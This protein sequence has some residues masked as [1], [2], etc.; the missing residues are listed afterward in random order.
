M[1][2]TPPVEPIS[3][4]AIQA[5][6][7]GSP[8]H[9]QYNA[10]IR[11]IATRLNKRPE[12]VLGAVYCCLHPD[13]GKNRTAHAEER[14]W[15]EYLPYL[16][17]IAAREIEKSYKQPPHPKVV[18]LDEPVAGTDGLTRGDTLAAP[19]PDSLSEEAALAQILEM[20]ET[21][22]ACSSGK[23]ERAVAQLLVERLVNQMPTLTQEKMANQVGCN[24]STVGRILG[25]L[26]SQYRAHY[27]CFR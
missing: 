12:Q 11:E 18:S 19:A 24:Q 23:N 8:E 14:T 20:L 1:T 6:P 3:W 4:S 15:A 10:I 13:L 27:S 5:S 26:V 25:K 22:S 17:K 16:R 7:A 2:D 21:V 9:E